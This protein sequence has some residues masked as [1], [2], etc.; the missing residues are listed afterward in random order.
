MQE[1][2]DLQPRLRYFVNCIFCQVFAVFR[3]HG[4]LQIFVN[5]L[6]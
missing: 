5:V 2:A 4:H 3:F 1:F 6:S